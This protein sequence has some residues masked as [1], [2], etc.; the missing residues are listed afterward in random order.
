MSQERLV[1]LS[2]MS[3]EQEIL[4]NLNLGTLIEEF[5]KMKSHKVEFM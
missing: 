3:I 1:G 5:A 2:F 4:N